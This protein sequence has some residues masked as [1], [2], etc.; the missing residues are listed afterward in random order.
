ML[1]VCGRRREMEDAVTAAPSFIDVPALGPS[2]GPPSALGG[3]P[4]SASGPG[5]SSSRSGGGTSP[6]LMGR[7]SSPLPLHFFGVFDGHGGFQVAQ[8]CAENFHRVLA[9]EFRRLGP[10]HLP[11][12]PDSIPP[13]SLHGL[14]QTQPQAPAPAHPHPQPEP[15]LQTNAQSPSQAQAQAQAQAWTQQAQGLGALL[16]SSSGAGSGGGDDGDGLP[17]G[18][19]GGG[20]ELEAHLRQALYAAFSRI[21][22]E[23]GGRCACA[24]EAAGRG[25]CKHLP[26]AGETVGST[27]V[28]AVVNDTKI[29]VANCG[30]SR[31]VLSRGGAAVPLSCDQKVRRAAVR[32]APAATAAAAEAG[33]VAVCPP[34]GML[35]VCGRRREMEDAVTAAPSFIDVPALGPSFGP[36]SALGGSPGSASGPGYSSSRSG[37]GTSPQLMGR[38]SSPLPLHFFGVFDGHGGFQVA[39]FC[40]ENFHRVLAEEFRRLGPLHLPTAPDSIPPISLHG[41]P[42]TQPQ[43]PA[44]AHPHPQPEPQLQTNAQSPSQAQAQ[45]QAQAWTQQAQGLGALLGSSSGAGS[46]GGDDGDGLPGGGGGGGAELEAHLRQALY[47]AFS[48][49]DAEVGGR[50]ACAPE[51]AGRGECKHLPVAGETVGSTAVVAVVND[52]KIVVANCGDSRAVLSRGGAAVPLSCDQKL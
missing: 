24:P 33:G 5:Y 2:F 34:H 28:V 8:F 49:I 19:G 20:A 4:G 45:A 14:P 31:A 38:E 52:T 21:D 6:Q 13:I 36:P 42:Q 43:A 51:A 17:G 27:A 9:E 7:E 10:L 32:S 23:V 46:G 37:G 48:R 16:G 30:D 1:S 11:T 18:G 40:A 39:Q 12:A 3:S 15:Q 44:P 50:C 22:A 29:V 26:V 47:A 41:L 35:S 25:E